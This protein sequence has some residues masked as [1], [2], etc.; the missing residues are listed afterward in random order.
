VI[1]LSMDSLRDLLAESLT[2]WHFRGDVRSTGGAIWLSCNGAEI[3]VEPAPSGSPFRWMVTVNGRKRAALALPAVL[4]RV[5]AALD[6]QYER[7]QVRIA[8]APVVPP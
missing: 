5:R 4:R 2:A 6:P 7:Y 8:P 3:R 1:D